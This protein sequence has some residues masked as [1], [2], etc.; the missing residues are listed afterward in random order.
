MNK[1]GERMMKASKLM[2]TMVASSLLAVSLNVFAAGSL[3]VEKETTVNASPATVWKMIGNFNG[4]DVWHPVV[5]GSELTTGVNNE[6]GAVRLLTLGNGAT[7]S[8]KLLSYSDED[9]SYSYA[10]M[11]SP[12]PVSNYESSISVM[13]AGEGKSKIVWRSDFDTKDATDADAV[14]AITGVY[15]A[16]LS[17]V[18][19]HFGN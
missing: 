18:Q 2:N 14:D 12:L 5:V 3:S 16:G 15:D 7:I 6:P 17:Q 19:K 4:L 1:A 13:D 11:E 8:E 9:K 10:I